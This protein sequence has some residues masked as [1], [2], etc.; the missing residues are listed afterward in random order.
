MLTLKVS[1]GQQAG[2]HSPRCGKGRRASQ[3][4]HR[5]SQ[6]SSA[7]RAAVTVLT[8]QLARLLAA[9]SLH[10]VANPEELGLEVGTPA[11]VRRTVSAF[12]RACGLGGA[13]PH[14]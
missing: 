9:M 12:F 10:A 2:A 1:G 14:V 5:P 3:H 8:A 4:L 6:Q 7:P 11:T 13:A